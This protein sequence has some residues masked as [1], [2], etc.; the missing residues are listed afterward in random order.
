MSKFLAV[1]PLALTMN[2][3]PQIITNI[4]LVTTKNPVKKL[5]CYLASALVS[6]TVITMLAFVLFDLLN[7]S[8]KVSNNPSTAQRAV[9]LVFVGLLVFLIVRTFLKRKKRE[10]PRWL[11]EIEDASPRRVF[12]I[13]LM[14]FSFMPTDLITMITVAGYLARN[15]LHFYAVLPFIALTMILASLPLLF[16][17]LFRKPAQKIMPQVQDWLD[18]NAWIVNE[19]VLV[20]F[21]CMILFT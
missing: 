1:L 12:I 20:F 19:V 18:T 14:L 13:G 8:P 2:L 11:S 4:T 15:K 5:F 6:S 7:T 9:D 16:Y 3:G 17:L 21:I 10:I